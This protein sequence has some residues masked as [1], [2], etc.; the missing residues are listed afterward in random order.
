MI[1]PTTLST[2][3]EPTDDIWEAMQVGIRRPDIA[4]G[5]ASFLEKRPPEFPRLGS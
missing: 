1:D 4:E 2:G 3:R 5:V